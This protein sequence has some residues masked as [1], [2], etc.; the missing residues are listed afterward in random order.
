MSAW[1]LN[2]GDAKPSIAVVGEYLLEPER[3]KLYGVDNILER[4]V[5]EHG[6][7]WSLPLVRDPDACA[8]SSME[9]LP[10]SGRNGSQQGPVVQ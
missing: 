10:R 3:M 5:V 2:L 1:V 6:D 9:E 7:R 8:V 4:L